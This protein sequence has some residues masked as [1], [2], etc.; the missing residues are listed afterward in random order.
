MGC[1]ASWQPPGL[2]LRPV[3]DVLRAQIVVADAADDLDIDGL[4]PISNCTNKS[5][6]GGWYFAGDAVRVTLV[7]EPAF[8]SLVDAEH[9]VWKCVWTMSN[10]SL[11][12]VIWADVFAL[13]LPA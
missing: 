5:F 6:G 1:A 8:H 3:D 12:D 7:D 4:S 10:H 11:Y 13:V 2:A 9:E